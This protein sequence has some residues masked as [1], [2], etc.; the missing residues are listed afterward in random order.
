MHQGWILGALPTLLAAQ[1]LPATPVLPFLDASTPAELLPL[2]PFRLERGP[3]NSRVPFDWRGELQEKADI[4]VLEHGAIQAEGILLLADRIE[5]RIPDGRLIAEGHVR[6]EGP[7][8]RLRGERL[9]MDWALRSGEAWALQ[10]D[11]PPTWSLRSS[12]VAFTT[13]R[14]WVF[15]EVDLSPCPEEKPGW[16][17]KLSSLKV[18]L[19]GFATLWNARIQLGSV[20]IFYLPYALYPA[21][22]ERT[23]GL[24]APQLGL[25]SAFGTTVG[26][27]YFQVLGNTVDATLAPEYFSKE[28]MLWA[29]ETRWHPDLTHQGSFSGLTIHQKSLDAQ[30]FRYSLKEVWQREDGWQLTADV[31][32]ASDNLVDADFG[33]GLG[34]LGATNFDS[35]LYLGRSFTFGSLS[36]NAAEQ[37]SFFST[38]SQGDPFY[39]PQFPASLRRQT[40]PQAEFRFFPVSLLGPLYLDGGLRLGR[41]AYKIQGTTTADQRFAWDRQDANTRLHGRLGQWGPFRADFEMMGRATHYSATLASPVFDPNGGES[42]TVVNPATSPFQ[43]DGKPADRFLFSSHLRFSG[44]QVGRTFKEVSILGYRGLL[45]HVVEPYFGVT[46]TSR[47]GG[48]GSLPRFDAVDFIP[49]VNDSA[50]GERSFE[51]GLKQHILGRASSGTG[52]ADLVRLRVATRFHST[53]VILSDGTYKKGWASIDTDLDVEPDDRWRLSLRRSSDLAAGGSDN[54]LSLDVKARDGGRFNLAYFSTGI[55]QLL[56]RQQ[57]LQFGGVERIWDDRLRFEFSA[58][59]DFRTHG[60]ASSSVALAWVQPC[61]AYVLKYTHVA[62]NTNLVSGGREDRVDLTLTLRGLGNLFSLRR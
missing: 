55:N 62:L 58:N 2:R 19:D 20:P 3:G 39:S 33:R 30:R 38:A 8:L 31:N 48:V 54:S 15:E 44:P 35:A 11:L 18:D 13:L 56:V 51:L 1:G 16:R 10:M 6:L 29:G 17:A 26:I 49:G 32:Q 45:K 4:W 22:A 53:P 50:S 52:L 46:Q 43:V 27:S 37:R 21:Q 34:N 61:V 9:Q 42:G 40:L 36:L 23:S 7:D 57:G 24:L 25:S 14:T 41:Y 60:F 28:G 47:Y 5:Y 12:H 59:Y